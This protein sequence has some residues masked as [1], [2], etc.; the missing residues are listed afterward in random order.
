MFYLFPRK[1]GYVYARRLVYELNYRSKC[2]EVADFAVFL[3]HTHSYSSILNRYSFTQLMKDLD[4][5]LK[6]YIRKKLGSRLV[7]KHIMDS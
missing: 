2:P 6:A 4:W 5:F 7:L 3:P 1:I